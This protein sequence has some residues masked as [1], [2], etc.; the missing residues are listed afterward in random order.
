MGARYSLEPR[1]TRCRK[2]AGGVW[3]LRESAWNAMERQARRKAVLASLRAA[4]AEGE[5]SLAGWPAITG[6]FNAHGFRNR[7]GG[8]VTEHAVKGWMRS[9]TG[10]IERSSAKRKLARC[11]DST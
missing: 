2:G 3:A 6:W 5:K 11:S 8:A 9:G 10:P 1:R 4:F 7:E